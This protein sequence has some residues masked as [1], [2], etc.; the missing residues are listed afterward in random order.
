ML[1]CSDLVDV[2]NLARS[3]LFRRISFHQG[4]ID[5]LFTYGLAFG[6][7]ILAGFYWC[8]VVGWLRWLSPVVERVT[9][10]EGAIGMLTLALIAVSNSTDGFLTERMF[11]YAVVG[12][13]VNALWERRTGAT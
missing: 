9:W 7:L 5:H 1:D 4:F 10:D 6:G 11:M 8:L 2:P 3:D 12:L 13:S